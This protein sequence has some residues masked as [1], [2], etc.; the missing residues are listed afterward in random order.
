MRL[1]SAV[2]APEGIARG[3]SSNRQQKSSNLFE[4][5]HYCLLESRDASHGGGGVQ[6]TLS[7][8]SF[9]RVSVATQ[10]IS[11]LLPPSSENACSKRHELGVM[12]ETTNRTRITRPSSVS[13]SKNS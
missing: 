8:S 1:N 4:R 12:S 6:C 10:F 11:Q 9:T 3:Q 5:V 7:D 2:Q 13:W